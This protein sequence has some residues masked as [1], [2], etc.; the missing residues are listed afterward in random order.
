[1]EKTRLP[2]IAMEKMVVHIKGITPIMPSAM[3]EFTEK[4]EDEDKLYE[5]CFYY[6][7]NGNYAMPGTGAKKMLVNAGQRFT[8]FAGTTLKGALFVMAK[9]NTILD[10]EG[11]P[12]KKPIPST[13]WITVGGRMRRQKTRPTF[14]N[15]TMDIPVTYLKSVLNSTQILHIFQIAGLAIGYSTWRPEKGGTYGQF[16]VTGATK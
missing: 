5:A 3:H 10:L 4:T 16:E 1:M 8:K 11:K 15:W 2:E 13:D 9:W 14:P 7:E 6:D 12:H